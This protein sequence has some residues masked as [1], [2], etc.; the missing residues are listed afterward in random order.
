MNN[1]QRFMIYHFKITNTNMN[2]NTNTNNSHDW[3]RGGPVETSGGSEAAGGASDG[4]RW[5]ASG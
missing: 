3:E 4:R 2:P 5:R 1:D